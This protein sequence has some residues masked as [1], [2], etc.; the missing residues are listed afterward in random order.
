MR[1]HIC[2]DKHWP[3]EVGS[4]DQLSPLKFGAEARNCI[5]RILSHRCQTSGDDH[6]SNN[7]HDFKGWGENQRIILY[8]KT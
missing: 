7:Q 5:W 4:G 2:R 6:M 8:D 3:G 1:A